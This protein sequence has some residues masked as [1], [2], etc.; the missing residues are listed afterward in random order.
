MLIKRNKHHIPALLRS[1][2]AAIMPCIA[3]GSFSAVAQYRVMGVV[4]D[5]ITHEPLE[6]IKVTY[7]GEKR[8]VLTDVHGQFMLHGSG[9]HNAVV[10]SGMGYK[11]EILDIPAGRQLFMADTIFMHPSEMELKEVVVKG[12][13]AKYSKKNN[14]AVAFVNRLR[15]RSADFD[16]FSKPYYSFDKYEK[17]ILGYYLGDSVRVDSTLRRFVDNSTVTGEPYLTISLKEKASKMLN[18]SSPKK[19]KEL[20]GGYRSFGIDDNLDRNNVRKLVEDILREI[21]IYSN[22][23]TLMQNRFVS[24]LSKIGPDFYRY[25]LTDTVMINDVPCIELVFGP[26]NRE[27]FGFN[28]RIYVDLNDTSMFV[29]K[30]IMQTPKAINLNYIDGIYMVQNF[31]KDSLGIRHKDYD[32]I[33]ADIGILPGHKSLYAERETRY[34]DFSYDRQDK[35]DYVYEAM[36]DQIF[37]D[38]AWTRDDQWWKQRRMDYLSRSQTNMPSFMETLR[39]NKLYYWAEKLIVRLELGYFTTGKPSKF[40]I[41]PINTMISANDVEGARFRLGGITTGNLSQHW[42]GRGYVAYGTKDKKFKYEG[43]VEYSFIPKKYHSRDFPMNMLR[44]RY[45]YDVDQIGQH[46]LFTNPDNVFLSLKRMENHLMTYKREAELK[47]IL[48]LR[49]GFSVEASMGME[50]Q[51]ATRWLSFETMDGAMRHAY[52]KNSMKVTLRYAPGEEFY[53][54]ATMRLPINLDNPVFMISQEYGPKRLFGNDFT[55]NKTEVSV[56]KRFWFSA[57]GYTDI[58]LKG[59]KI[60]SKVYYPSLA[61]ANANLSYVIQ[62]ESFDLMNPMEFAADQYLSWDM[63]YW[64]NGI[65]FNRIPFLKKLKMREVVAFRG[66]YGSLTDKNDPVKNP[67]LLRFP[68]DADVSRLGSTPYMEAAVGLDNILTFL[69]VD[70]VWRLTYRNNPGISKSG[71]RI[72]LHFTF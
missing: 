29:R 39:K 44:L 53:Q 5:S 59:C 45:S 72:A 51:Y 48:E 3:V 28:G 30:V 35:L 9:K 10:F 14:P 38:E 26:H 7:R 69:R 65:L 13:R 71:V 47:Y 12:K 20:V 8:G 31:S 6:K 61:W 52:R 37:P 19:K 21:D 64:G 67:E 41:G 57:F 25:F 11:K 22:D 43:L 63:T 56:Q 15:S 24:P 60:W 54:S 58:I 55:I 17:F 23:I 49:N 16:P 46:Y 36:E 50:K 40:D 27:T 70:Y 66:Y 4:V 68:A 18:S 62:P 1:V 42:F 32:R 33:V 2:L 34:S